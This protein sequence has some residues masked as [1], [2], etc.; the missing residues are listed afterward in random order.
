MRGLIEEYEKLIKPISRSTLPPWFA[1]SRLSINFTCWPHELRSARVARN[2]SVSQIKE[3][4]ARLRLERASCVCNCPYYGGKHNNSIKACLPYFSV[5]AVLLAHSTGGDFFLFRFIGLLPTPSPSLG[6]SV[7][8]L[9]LHRLPFDCLITV[10]WRIVARL[11]LWQNYER[12]TR[13]STYTRI[14]LLNYRYSL[15]IIIYAI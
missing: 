15:P 11:S 9:K 2:S 10:A 1:S 7:R 13:R 6:S 5:S 8:S 12:A 3:N 14:H 4:P